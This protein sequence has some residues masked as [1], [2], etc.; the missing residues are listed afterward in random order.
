MKKKLVLEQSSR[1]DLKKALEKGCISKYNWIKPGSARF[2]RLTDG[3]DVIAAENTKGEPIRFFSDFS[4][5][6]NVT[7]QQG[8]WECVIPDETLLGKAAV[9]PLTPTDIINKY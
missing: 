6:N 4:V 3:R 8:R 5:M 9:K 1:V 2:E 7:K